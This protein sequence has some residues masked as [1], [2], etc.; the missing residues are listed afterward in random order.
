MKKKFK[1]YCN[2]VITLLAIVYMS[3]CSIFRAEEPIPDYFRKLYVPI[4]SNKTEMPGIE[5]DLTYAVWEEMKTEGSLIPVGNKNNADGVLLL[6]IRIYKLE[7]VTFTKTG[8]PDNCNL[9]I[10][11]TLVVNN[12]IDKTALIVDQNFEEYINFNLRTSPS[13][14]EQGAMQRLIKQYAESI[15]RKVIHGF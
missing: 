13:E 15:V 14:S 8:E 6:E 12:L 9:R 11:S 2:L 4:F 5:T 3:G 7:P 10:V 1:T